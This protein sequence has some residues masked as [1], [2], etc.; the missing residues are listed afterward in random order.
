[1]SLV[2]L[3]LALGSAVLHASWNLL[4]ARARHTQAAAAM[5]L[6]IGVVA[7]AP[8][9]LLL[10]P[11]LEPAVVPY[12]VAS[13]LLE[14][15]YFVLLT[16]AYAASEMSLVYPIARG[17][18]P[19]MVLL[20]GVLIL[21]VP[22]TPAHL[23]G[24]A[25][26]AAGVLLVRGIR[27]GSGASGVPL[28]L[29]IAAVIAAYTY[30]DRE[31][32]RYASAPL[33]V[34]LV[35]ALPGLAFAGIVWRRYGFDALRAELRPATAAAGLLLFTAYTMTVLALRLAPAPVVA[36]I[37]ESSVV[38]AALLAAVVLRERVGRARLAGTVVVF[39]GVAVLALG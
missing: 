18:A 28:G 38:F 6:V 15:L 26:V 31:G 16:A 2:A 30:L 24:V 19:V 5:A 34:V 22:A 1:V 12:L 37:R 4:L 20:V 35:L 8:V 7:Y 11:R 27:G 39:A 23:V 13:A 10:E 17:M 33:Y 25:L 21:A 29:A 9:A 36:A 3:A 14:L 32:V